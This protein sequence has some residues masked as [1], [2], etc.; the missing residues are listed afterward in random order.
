MRPSVSVP[1]LSVSR[2]SMSPRSSMHTRRLTRTPWWARRR[3]PV[4]RLV[5]TTAGSS[6]GVIPTAIASE[7]SSDSSSDRCKIRLM[8]KIEVLR[9]PATSTSST[10]KC[11]KPAWNSV[12][13]WR[14]PNPAAILPNSVARPVLTTTPSPPPLLTTVPMNAHDERSASAQSEGTGVVA[15]SAGTDSP[16]STPSS[17]SRPSAA[18]IRTSAG[19]T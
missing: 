9:T 13:S 17:H 14:S 4:A 16:V 5:V 8:T 19:T 1:V 11:R 12:T 3:D 6:C 10:E 2:I 18:T 15:L 7:N